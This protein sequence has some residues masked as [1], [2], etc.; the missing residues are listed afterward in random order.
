MILARNAETQSRFSSHFERKLFKKTYLAL[1]TGAVP[2]QQGT[3]KSPL[4]QSH[5]KPGFMCIAPKKGKK[6]ATDWK[7]L[8]D[9]GTVALLAVN[10]VTGRTHQIR[11][12][13]P[14]I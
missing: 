2:R 6:A 4:A 9:F 3:I 1:V 7:L 12:H 14:H 13:L 5:K 8:A 11:V 10:P